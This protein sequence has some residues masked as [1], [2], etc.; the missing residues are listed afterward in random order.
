MKYPLSLEIQRGRRSRGRTGRGGEVDTEE[1]EKHVRG[2]EIEVGR[3]AKVERERER[4]R[5][6]EIER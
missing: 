3:E 5:G 1:V 2:K 4:E 6:A